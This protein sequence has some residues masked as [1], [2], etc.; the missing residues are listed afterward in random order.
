MPEIDAIPRPVVGFADDFPGGH[1]IPRHRHLRGQL[2][3]ASTGVMTVT[4]GEGI[5]V[6]PPQRAVWVPGKIRHEIRMSG[7]VVMETL[8]LSDRALHGL[9]LDCRVVAISPLLEQL[10]RRIVAMP[11]P[12]PKGGAEERL[13][14]VALDEIRTM[15][16]AAFHLPRPSDPR[17]RRV[18]EALFENP[19]DERG[20]GEWAA[21]AAASPRTLARL[22]QRETG[23]SFGTWR[24]QL[25]LQRALE[26]LAGGESVTAIALALG[27]D[28]T[29]A[30]I[31]MFR[32]HLG[33][34]P[35]SYFEDEGRDSRPG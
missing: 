25:R 28:S 27:Y 29:S 24:R 34:T 15:E 2:I 1:V 31:S 16:V 9:P 19:A 12:Y 33:R 17:L 6:V 21:L 26:C 20:L 23:M 3:H 5:W 7:R 18:T 35:G 11:R 10:I 22:F 32:R 4:T 14:G 30:F 13:V 8:Y